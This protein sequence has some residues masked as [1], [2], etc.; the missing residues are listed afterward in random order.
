MTYKGH[1]EKGLVVFDEPMPLADGTEVRV[2][3]L[4]SVLVDET[5]PLPSLA[6]HLA[7]FIGK[8]KSLPPDA[9]ENHD[10]YL[11]GAPKR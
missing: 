2:E 8:A 7:A 9:A 6:E 4:A 11:Y 5:A 10:H 3:V 1:V